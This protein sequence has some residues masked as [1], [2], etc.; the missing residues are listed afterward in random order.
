MSTKEYHYF[1][2][3]GGAVMDALNKWKAEY[4]VKRDARNAAMEEFGADKYFGNS[5]GL[6]GLVFTPGKEPEGWEKVRG[7]YDVY[8]PTGKTKAGR[9]LR[10]RLARLDVP[11][12]L[13]FQR[14]VLG[15]KTDNPFRFMD[16]LS[17]YYMVFETIGEVTILKVPK[18][19]QKDQWTPPDDQCIPLKTSE[20][21]QIKE[22]ESALPAPV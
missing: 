15:E 18:T 19:P 21:W 4:T 13:Q 5:A 14:Y 10:R 12:A 3:I 2:V 9:E 22:S 1:K 20:Y 16:G 17:M 11:D 6:Q 8:K 7:H